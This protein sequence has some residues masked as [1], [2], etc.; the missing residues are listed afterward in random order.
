MFSGTSSIPT[1]TFTM[2]KGLII[3]DA[4]SLL[5]CWKAIIFHRKGMIDI[6]IMMA[7]VHNFLQFTKERF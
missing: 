4:L 6:H 5:G 7:L 1:L 2:K 3:V